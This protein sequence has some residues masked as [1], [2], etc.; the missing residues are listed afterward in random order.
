M[1]YQEGY[2]RIRALLV[3]GQGVRE[4]PYKELLLW[5]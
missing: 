3:A 4:M 5:W 1:N 2:L